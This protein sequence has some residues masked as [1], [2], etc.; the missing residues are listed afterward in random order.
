MNAL[1]NRRDLAQFVH[2]KYESRK[3]ANEENR[4]NDARFKVLNETKKQLV[5]ELRNELLKKI[6]SSGDDLHVKVSS[7]NSYKGGVSDVG[8][9]GTRNEGVD[10]VPTIA[11][12][13][14]IREA[15][16]DHVSKEASSECLRLRSSAHLHLVGT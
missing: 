7:P 6:A 1:R 9:K 3:Q 13:E 11:S 16:L 10:L 12:R 15:F 5:I 8:T 2:E 4:K 14:D